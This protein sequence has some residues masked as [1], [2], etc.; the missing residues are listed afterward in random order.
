MTR[1]DQVEAVAKVAGITAA[2]ARLALDA[3]GGLVKVGLLE[4]ERF[5]L[6]GVGTFTVQ[7]RRAR[8]I[9]N[10]RTG[11]IMELPAVSAVKF[12]PTPDLRESVK[13]RHP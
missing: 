10:P 13:T 8:N 2:Q 1:R 11:L 9:T 7:R 4:E 6:A 3:V 12:R 5:T